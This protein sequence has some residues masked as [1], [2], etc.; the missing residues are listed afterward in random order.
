MNQNIEYVWAEMENFYLN[1][2]I[3]L[4]LFL[5]DKDILSLCSITKKFRDFKNENSLEIK[6]FI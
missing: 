1:I 5:S 3:Y 6:G 4:Q 2:I